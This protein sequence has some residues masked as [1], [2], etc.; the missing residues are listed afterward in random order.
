MQLVDKGVPEFKNNMIVLD[1][2]VPKE[3][4]YKAKAQM[5]QKAGNIIFLPLVIEKEIFALL[6]NH[7]AFLRFQETFSPVSGFTYDV[8]FNNWPLDVHEY[9]T[10]DLKNWYIYAD[11]ILGDSTILFDFWCSENQD[12]VV[13][14]IEQFIGVFN[15][16]AER[17]AVDA[18][19]ITTNN[20]INT[21]ASQLG[22]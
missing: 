20:S 8:C 11:N 9:N 16:L 21:D 18:L 3:K 7:E 19:P 14:F 22:I 17:N 5:I 10:K 13:A 6:K 1:G 2:D 15:Q 12:A 4:G